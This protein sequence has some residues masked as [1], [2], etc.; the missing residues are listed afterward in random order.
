LVTKGE[1]DDCVL[2]VG[3]EDP[4][5]V[6]ELA[7]GMVRSCRRV[8]ASRGF[9][10]YKCVS[11]QGAA[12]TLGVT[13]VGPSATEI[14]FIEYAAC[15]A[16]LFIRAGTSGSISAI[17]PLGSVVIS[18]RA[19]RYDGVSDLYA[20]RRVRAT[21]S[22][23]VIRALER[24]AQTLG[25]ECHL[26]VTLSTS[27]FYAMGDSLGTGLGCDGFRPRALATL[28]KPS[29]EGKVLNVEM[30]TATPLTLSR[31]YGLDGGSVCGISNKVPWAEG[32][33]HANTRRALVNAMGVATEAITTVLRVCGK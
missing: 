25:V 13:G 7:A 3:G 12:F 16:R 8:A 28:Q 18:S 29:D 33:Q 11:K 23:R 22:P 2:L 4:P 6:E 10:T 14:A 9:F 31:V 24:S 20:G 27:A 5:L 32:E 19:L 30:E 17:A 1:V 21:A 15:G 26:G